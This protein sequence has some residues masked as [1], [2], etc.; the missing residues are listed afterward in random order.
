MSSG[1]CSRFF[2][3]GAS[4]VF[5]TEGGHQTQQ[6]FTGMPDRF[7]ISSTELSHLI[8]KFTEPEYLP[9][10]KE[11]RID[12]SKYNLYGGRLFALASAIV[13][14]SLTQSLRDWQ[15]VETFKR[16]LKEHLFLRAYMEN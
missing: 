12:S 6:R 2:N 3:R 9:Q 16:K 11:K 5:F 10:V 13:W 7:A 15:S 1:N 4:R 8:N 14:N